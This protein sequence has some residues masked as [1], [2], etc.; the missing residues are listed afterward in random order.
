MDYQNG[1]PTYVS[2]VSIS[3]YEFDSALQV[4]VIGSVFVVQTYGQNL[5]TQDEN[6]VLQDWVYPE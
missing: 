1:V 6:G 5:L 3:G 2:Y 4:Q